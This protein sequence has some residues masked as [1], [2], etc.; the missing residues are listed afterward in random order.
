MPKIASG[1]LTPATVDVGQAL[2]YAQAH[3]KQAMQLTPREEELVGK[4][5]TGELTGAHAG[6]RLHQALDYIDS[7]HLSKDEKLKLGN[8]ME[9][10]RDPG[11][12]LVKI[13]VTGS[14]TEQVILGLGLMNN[15]RHAAHSLPAV[16]FPQG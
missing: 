1:P 9:H 5:L 7:K 2:A 12:P 16:P 6:K 13:H 11:T 15:D 10:V 3:R 8:E 4:I 14:K